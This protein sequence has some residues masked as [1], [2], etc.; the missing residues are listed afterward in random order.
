MD[1][2]CHTLVGA[3]LAEAGLKRRTPYGTA[4]L[5]ISANLPDLDALVFF[6]DTPSVSFRRGW[7][8]GLLADAFL[9]IA[10]TAAVMVWGRVAARRRAGTGAS[11]LDPAALLA[12]SYVGLFSHVLLD[13][14]NSYG[15]R[16]LMPFSGRWFYGDSVFII[17][18]WLWLVFGL[19]VAWARARATVAPARLALAVAA[20][21]IAGMLWLGVYSRQLVLHGWQAAHGTSP[22]M[23]MVGPVPLDPFRKAIIVDAGDHYETGTLTLWPRAIRFD[24]RAVAKNDEGPAVQRARADPK[25]QA[26]LIWARFPYY[27]IEPSGNGV[28]VT[29]RD[30]RFGDRLG[31]ATVNVAAE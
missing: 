25:V 27:E 2:L 23:L 28:L 7:T 15:I 20:V 10:L 9:P 3:A 8:H 22:R 6:T 29:L 12:L 17:D 26:I 30:L 13:F 24:S 11:K 21:Y 5:L 18:P 31:V 19:G 16:L 1:N 14:L 4:T